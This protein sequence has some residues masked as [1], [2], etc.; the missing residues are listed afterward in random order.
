MYELIDWSHLDET[1]GPRIGKHSDD[2]MSF[3]GLPLAAGQRQ[4]AHMI[5]EAPSLVEPQGFV[6]PKH[7]LGIEVHLIAEVAHRSQGVHI[8][9]ENSL[10]L[11]PLELKQRETLFQVSEV[12]LALPQVAVS[13][14]IL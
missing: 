10:I 11:V 3:I 9:G 5:T 14:L 2:L 4:V 12:H 1:N 13:A 8:D 7:S 6:I